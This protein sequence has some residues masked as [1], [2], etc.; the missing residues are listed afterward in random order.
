MKVS[1]F[2]LDLQPALAPGSKAVGIQD[3]IIKFGSFNLTQ[4]NTKDFQSKIF[5]C[6]SAIEL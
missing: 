5:Y 4:F 6:L 3:W 2:T 1:Y